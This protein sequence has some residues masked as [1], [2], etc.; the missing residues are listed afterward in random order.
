MHRLTADI[1]AIA[2]LVPIQNE[3][4]LK[5]TGCL[6]AICIQFKRFNA[7]LLPCLQILKGINNIALEEIEGLY[8]I[9][10]A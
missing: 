4:H 9:A 6:G 2:I 1:H 10:L 7:N 3:Y 5:R 8:H